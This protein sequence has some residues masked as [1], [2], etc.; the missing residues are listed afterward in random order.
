MNPQN[1]FIN[2]L[3]E[4]A[5]VTFLLAY[6]EFDYSSALIIE[7]SVIHVWHIG[8]IDKTQDGKPNRNNKKV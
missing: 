4:Q 6:Q 5:G 1:L 2:I 3:S 7:V 8:D